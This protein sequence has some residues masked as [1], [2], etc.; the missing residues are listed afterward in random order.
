M[1]YYSPVKLSEGGG[2]TASLPASEPVKGIAN[3][4]M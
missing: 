3:K 2:L 1:I 4:K